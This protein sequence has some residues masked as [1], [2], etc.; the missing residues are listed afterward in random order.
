MGPGVPQGLRVQRPRPSTTRRCR[1]APQEPDLFP[2]LPPLPCPTPAVQSK[3]GTYGAV[4]PFVHPA[5]VTT[6][7]SWRHFGATDSTTSTHS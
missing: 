5:P 4:S 6:N 2:A 3:A 7:T 1:A